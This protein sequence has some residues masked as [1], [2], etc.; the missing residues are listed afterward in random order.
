LIRE[1]KGR[2]SSRPPERECSQP[3][4]QPARS[5]G[6]PLHQHFGTSWLIV[7]AVLGKDDVT[8]CLKVIIASIPFILFPFPR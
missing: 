2:A 1:K 5:L 7:D 4:S 6:I 3:A 8:I